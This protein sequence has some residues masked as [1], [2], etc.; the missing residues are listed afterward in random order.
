MAGV[1]FLA[2][3]F[4]GLGWLTLTLSALAGLPLLSEASQVLERGETLL[5]VGSAVLLPVAGVLVSLAGF[6]CWAVLTALSEIHD[7][8]AASNRRA[9]RRPAVSHEPAR[10]S[11]W[12]DRAR[13]FRQ[14]RGPLL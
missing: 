3:I 5:A 9:T 11:Y 8:V 13:R 14:L 4:L 6:F 12:E 10:P 7:R 1:R 2:W